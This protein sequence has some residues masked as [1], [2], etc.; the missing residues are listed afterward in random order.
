M[1]AARAATTSEVIGKSDGTFYRLVHSCGLR[2]RNNLTDMLGN[3]F[4]P[5]VSS[6]SS[7]FLSF[8]SPP[9]SY[10]TW[11]PLLV[12]LVVPPATFRHAVAAQ[13]A[14][15]SK[16]EFLE[17]LDDHIG[18]L[19]RLRMSLLPAEISDPTLR[20][21]FSFS[22]LSFRFFFFFL[23]S[24]LFFLAL[25]VMRAPS[26]C[27]WVLMRFRRSSSRRSWRRLWCS[28]PPMTS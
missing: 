6:L 24:F 4:L 21:F 8:P 15:I 23:T 20:Y 14:R 26:G 12:Q 25:L 17:H 11:S 10:F 1:A 5:F 16:S 13:L 22:F 27:C 18:D 7:F 2:I 3:S 28:R 19:V 9:L